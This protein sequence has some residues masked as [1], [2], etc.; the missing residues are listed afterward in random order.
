MTG[1]P[2]QVGYGYLETLGVELLEG[3]TFSKE[4]SNEE[5]NVII[6]ET[7]AK[8]IGYENP[9]GKFLNRGSNYKIQIIGVVKDFHNESLHEKIRPTFIRFL[10]TGKNVMVKIKTGEEA[11]TVQKLEKLYEAYHAGFPFNFTFLDDDYQTL[12]E[13]ES[14]VAT[15]SNYAAGV[16]IIISCLGLFALAMFTAE[17]RKKE[18]GIRKVLGASVINI[19]QLLSSRFINLVLLAFLIAS[20]LVYFYT[21]NWL[22]GF[23]FH[24]DLSWWFFVAAGAM[25][26]G[27]VF[28][29]VSFQSIKAAL[30]NP[31]NTLKSE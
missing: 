25:V 1:T 11:T 29:I 18:I 27:I 5:D 24:I 26:M 19:I 15:L 31:A 30:A 17:R 23:A 22:N 16:A 8:L 28:I 9:V 20:P 13:S 7:A 21:R 10:P 6:N 14:K 12:Y 4:F 3:R 2:S